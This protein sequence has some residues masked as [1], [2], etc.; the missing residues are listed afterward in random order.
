VDKRKSADAHHH[1]EQAFEELQGGYGSQHA[2]LIAM[3]I[4]FPSVLAHER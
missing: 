1:H 4:S 3:R 2:P